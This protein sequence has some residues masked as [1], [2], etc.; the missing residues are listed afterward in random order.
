MK[1]HISRNLKSFLVKKGP[2]FT[3]E[4]TKPEVDLTADMLAR[5]E[6]HLQLNASH[7]TIT[8]D[9]CKKICGSFHVCSYRWIY[10]Y[11]NFFFFDMQNFSGSWRT[12]TFKKYNFNALGLASTGGHLHPLMKVRSEF[13]EIFFQMGFVEMP[14]NRFV[15]FIFKRI[16]RFIMYIQMP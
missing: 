10:Y 1:L 4:L 5:F 3:T 2:N 12:S 15:L 8:L 7:L 6:F 13:R 16:C 14:T 11:K 9:N